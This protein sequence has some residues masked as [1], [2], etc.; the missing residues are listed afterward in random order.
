MPSRKFNFVAAITAAAVV[1]VVADTFASDAH[2]DTSNVSSAGFTVTYSAVVAAEPEQVWQAFTQP[3]R[4]WK[5]THPW[6]GQSADLGLDKLAAPVDEVIGEQVK[7][8]KAFIE[9][10]KPE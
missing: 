10:G 4:W 7:R 9:T 3:P 1:S 6:S 5:S 2:A 8:L